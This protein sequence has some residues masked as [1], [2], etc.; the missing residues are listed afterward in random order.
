MNLLKVQVVDVDLTHFSVPTALYLFLAG[1]V[2]ITAMFLP[3]I[4]GSTVLLIFGVHLPVTQWGQRVVASALW[5]AAHDHR[6]WRG[7]YLRCA[8]SPLLRG[9][10]R[11]WK[12]IV[13]KW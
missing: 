7:R 13:V 8:G 6:L 5:G 2:A 10:G 1:A 4:S 11:V 12:S 3:G 9:S